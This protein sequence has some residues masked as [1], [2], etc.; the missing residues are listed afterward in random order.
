MKN[1]ENLTAA[2]VIP[3]KNEA[4]FIAACLESV[5]AQDYPQHLIQIVVVDNDS[6]DDTAQ[7]ATRCGARLVR[8]PRGRV[9]AVRNLGVKESSS[10][11]VAFIDADCVA[12]ASWLSASIATLQGAQVGAV[13]GQYR[14]GNDANWV[15]RTLSFAGDYQLRPTHALAGGSFILKRE[16]FNRLRGFNEE[17][18]AAED[19]DLSQRIRAQGLELRMNP[20]CDVQHLGYPDSLKGVGRRQIW[21]GSNQLD[22]LNRWYDSLNIATH[23]Y[24]LAATA[25]VLSPFVGGRIGIFMTAAG[26]ALVAGIGLLAALHKARQTERRLTV[27]AVLRHA[28]LQCFSLGGRSIGLLVNYSRKLRAV[29][30][31]K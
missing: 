25:V 9:G 29:I 21:L 2:I 5:K 24:L 4:R 14:A 28:L 3:A 13:G 15:Q 27:S 8:C 31:T 16:L 22:T 6:S 11:I 10:D 30:A 7:I 12:P 26:C 17:L 23:A 1:A 18:F 20:A 19:D